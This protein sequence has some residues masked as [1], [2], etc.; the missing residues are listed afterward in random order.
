M[1]AFRLFDEDNIREDQFRGWYE[2]IEERSG[3]CDTLSATNVPCENVCDYLIAFDIAATR[4]GYP[5]VLGLNCDVE[6]VSWGGHA[7]ETSE[8]VQC[9]ACAR[10]QW[11]I[12]TARTQA[13]QRE[14]DAHSAELRRRQSEVEALRRTSAGYWNSLAAIPF[15]TEC[16]MLLKQLGYFAATTTVTNDCNIDITL[17]RDGRRGAAQCKAWSKPCGVSTVREFLGTIHAEGLEFGFLIAKSGFTPRAE[18]LLRR[19]PI[20]EGWDLQRLVTLSTP[21]APSL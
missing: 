16:A 10:R 12:E 11:K 4:D 17:Q 1:R 18:L 5:S 9:A 14:E 20:I 21:R 13:R 8:V 2:S 3:R 19:L 15:E 7:D 6:V